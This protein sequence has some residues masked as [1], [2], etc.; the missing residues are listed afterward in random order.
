MKTQFKKALSA[1]CLATLMFATPAMAKSVKVTLTQ[2]DD[3]VVTGFV[4]KGDANSLM[5][6]QSPN[7]PVGPIYPRTRIKNLYW[8]DPEDW[9]AAWKLWTRRDYKGAAV[10]FETLSK[11]YANLALIEDSYGSKAKY[12]QGES[13][14]RTGEYAKL[15][16]VWE[17]VKAVKLSAGYQKQIQLFNFWGHVGKKLWEPLKLI[18][19]KFEVKDV[20][21]H[22]VPPSTM[23]LKKIEADLLIQI[24]YMRA[25]AVEMI[26]RKEHKAAVAALD[27]QDPE[28]EVAVTQAW[29]NVV[30]AM[31]DYAR[32]YTLTYMADRQIA[33][34]AMERCMA[35]YK[36]DPGLEDDYTMQMEAYATASFYKDLFGK[37]TVPAAYTGFLKVPEPPEEA[38]AELEKSDADEKPKPDPEEKKDEGDKDEKKDD[39]EEDKKDA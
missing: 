29:S 22:T 28:T 34:E 24:A 36:D 15:M 19:E 2:I 7:A 6:A 32:V 20:P 13:L 18:T 17:E 3:S 12:Y 8:E 5:I 1:A 4:V 26:A 38:P 30:S 27:P 35:I 14:R 33:K 39:K 21:S 16:D 37:G 23:P 31:P 9:K 10:A 25:I 11:T